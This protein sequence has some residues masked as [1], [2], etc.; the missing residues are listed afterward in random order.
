M[1]GGGAVETSAARPEEDGFEAA[2]EAGALEEEAL[3]EGVLEEGV[4]EVDV[5]AALGAEVLGAAAGEA[6][7]L[8]DAGVCAAAGPCCAAEPGLE[9]PLA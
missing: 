9:A 4:S 2:L 3:A 5:L 6:E 8:P 1:G 7:L